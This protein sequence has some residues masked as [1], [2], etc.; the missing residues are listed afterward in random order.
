M[1]MLPITDTSSISF[2]GN[3]LGP[4]YLADPEQGVCS[5]L[6]TTIASLDLSQAAE[7]WPYV[8]SALAAKALGQ[9]QQAVADSEELTWEFRRLFAIG[10]TA[11]P[12]PPWGSYYTDAE[13]AIVSETTLALRRWLDI[14]GIGKNED[15]GFGNN[16]VEDHIGQMLLLMAWVAQSRPELIEDFLG[17]HLLPWSNHFFIRLQSATQHPFYLGLATLSD[18]SLCGIRDALDIEVIYPHFYR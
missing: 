1:D 11:K 4:L 16:K 7:E 12:A 17:L 14:N 9:M 8:E 6:L 3:T 2:V 10:P 15:A 18:A 5:P 13:G